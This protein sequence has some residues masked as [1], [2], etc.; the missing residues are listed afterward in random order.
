FTTGIQE[1]L[2]QI[3]YHTST[4]RLEELP[5]DIGY[6]SERVEL[7][8]AS[9][10][11]FH[12]GGQSGATQLIVTAPFLDEALLTQLRELDDL[13]SLNALDAITKALV[14]ATDKHDDPELEEWRFGIDA[15]EA[16]G[17]YY[18]IRLAP[19]ELGGEF[20]KALFVI[21][22]DGAL[23]YDEVLRDLSGPFSVENALVK[24]AAAQNCYTGK[25]CHG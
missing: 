22:K 5:L 24:I 20:A 8:N 25:G 6:A 21:S 2:M 18:G 1:A 10:E 13:L 14:V 15:D 19:G 4:V 3:R 7:K 9:G 17:D 11:T 12:I 23:F 16:F